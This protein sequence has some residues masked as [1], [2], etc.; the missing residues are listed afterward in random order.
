VTS[1]VRDDDERTGEKSETASYKSAAAGI[2]G[3]IFSNDAEPLTLA[4]SR[5]EMLQRGLNK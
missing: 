2:A 4:R 1:F 3:V 5:R